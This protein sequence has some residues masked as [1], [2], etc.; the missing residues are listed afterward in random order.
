MGLVLG[1]GLVPAYALFLRNG[2]VPAYAPRAYPDATAGKQCKV[3]LVLGNG[4]VPPYPRRPCL[5][6]TGDEPEAVAH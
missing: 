3:G 6:A 2:L 4:L 5:D 1:N